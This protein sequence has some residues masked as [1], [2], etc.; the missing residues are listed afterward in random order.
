MCHSQLIS[1]I[2][3]DNAS[4]SADV[5]FVHGINADART[6]WMTENKTWV[7][8]ESWLYWLGKDI[9]DVAVWTLD[10]PASALAWQGHTMPLE[11]RADN[12]TN[13]LL[14]RLDL[15]SN[16]PIIFV[17]HSMGGLLVKHILRRA[18]SGDCT[19]PDA[20]SLIERTRGIVFLSTP[21]T[22]S[23]LA[24]LIQR[25][26]FLRPNA[27][28]SELQSYEPT[29][30]SLNNWFGT[31][32]N[33]LDLQVKGFY[34]MQPTPI[35]RNF[36][37]RVINTIVVDRDS[38][39]LALPGVSVT[40]LDK[41]HSSICWVESPYLSRNEDQLYNN[42]VSFIEQIIQQSKSETA[43]LMPEPI[44]PQPSA[45]PIPDDRNLRELLRNLT[46]IQ[47]DNLIIELEVPNGNISHNTPQNNR[48]NELWR[49]VISPAGCQRQ[50][51]WE[52]LSRIIN[53]L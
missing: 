25:L 43:N 13:L 49:W 15:D 34:E 32:F 14:T 40:P 33:N 17:T 29:L 2:K 27:N 26:V 47:F 38:A 1:V 22:G 50:C 52:E 16:R 4:R 36:V 31:N 37:G 21:H 9:P 19:E 41:D 20:N 11:E 51:L 3:D 24:N 5:I 46:T 8:K 7:L 10:Y 23:D 45:I 6:T 42:V 35:Q 12:I 48:V 39:T 28:V 30:V 18:L 53:P 44:P